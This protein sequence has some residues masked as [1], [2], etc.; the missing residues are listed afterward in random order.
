MT[1]QEVYYDI[2]V[3]RVT[4]TLVDSNNNVLTVY[5]GGQSVEITGRANISVPQMQQFFRAVVGNCGTK[6][7]RLGF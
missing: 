7:R 5:V 1:D 6:S 4:A 2:L 3:E